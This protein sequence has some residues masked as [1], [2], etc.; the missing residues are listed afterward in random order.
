MKTCMHCGNLFESKTPR[1]RFCEPR[2]GARDHNSRRRYYP[3][4][5]EQTYDRYIVSRAYKSNKHFK[6]ELSNVN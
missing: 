4:Y 5:N 3:K 2:C 1:Q 6:K